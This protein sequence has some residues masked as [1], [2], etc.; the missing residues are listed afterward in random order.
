V[1]SWIRD[2]LNDSAVRLNDE[3]SSLLIEHIDQTTATERNVGLPIVRRK[4]NITQIRTVVTDNIEPIVATAD[5]N[6]VVGNGEPFRGVAESVSSRSV[7][8]AMSTDC[9][10]SLLEVDKA[11]TLPVLVK[12]MEAWRIKCCSTNTKPCR[13]CTA[14]FSPL[15]PT[16]PPFHDAR[17]D[18]PCA[19]GRATV[20]L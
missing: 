6:P 2:P 9:R 3:N 10:D 7:A 14:S 1:D 15:V 19:G 16:I 13:R 11:L 5:D 12:D 8:F 20:L 18:T 4:R 17:I